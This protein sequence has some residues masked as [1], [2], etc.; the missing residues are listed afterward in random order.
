MI[1]IK[2]YQRMI[3]RRRILSTW[4]KCKRLFTGK[5][6]RIRMEKTLRDSSPG[7]NC[8][9]R[10][11]IRCK[12]GNGE[13]SNREYCRSRR[14]LYEEEI[15]FLCQRSTH[16]SSLQESLKNPVSRKM[17]SNSGQWTISGRWDWKGQIKLQRQRR[18]VPLDE[19]CLSRVNRIRCRRGQN[20]RDQ[21]E[22]I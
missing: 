8:A 20:N 2:L 13:H 22:Q 15:R 14:N 1:R 9:V 18:S 16:T 10:G 21:K 4:L 3:L 12:S 17:R 19:R 11:E 7:H 6:W 5:V